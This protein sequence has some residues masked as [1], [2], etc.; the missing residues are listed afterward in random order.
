VLG[1]KALNILTLIHHMITIHTALMGV[2]I[3][4][5]FLTAFSSRVSMILK[6]V[7]VIVVLWLTIFWWLFG[8]VS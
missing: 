6:I 2:S 3:L 5:M 1:S 8:D 4:L 7:T